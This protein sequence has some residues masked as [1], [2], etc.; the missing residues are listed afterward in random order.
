MLTDTYVY[1]VHSPC[2]DRCGKGIPF[3][4]SNQTKIVRSRSTKLKD[5]ITPEINYQSAIQSNIISLFFAPHTSN[6]KDQYYFDLDL[7]TEKKKR[8]IKHINTREN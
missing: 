7:C 1:I 6:L 2:V 5:M 8:T 3:I 4:K